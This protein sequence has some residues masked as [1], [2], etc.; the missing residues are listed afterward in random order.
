MK[1]RRKPVSAIKGLAPQLLGTGPALLNSWDMAEVKA[2]L[3]RKL[4]RKKFGR[5]YSITGPHQT[6]SHGWR[7]G[8]IRRKRRRR[9]ENIERERA[10]KNSIM[11]EGCVEVSVTGA[12]AF[13]AAHEQFLRGKIPADELGFFNIAKQFSRSTE[14]I[15]AILQ[16]RPNFK[17]RF[18][19][20]NDDETLMW[21][22]LAVG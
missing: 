16:D 19:I 13:R 17:L 1:K 7:Y 22:K 6:N 11:L 14:D 18:R 15:V 2:S 21:F 5:A 8:G 4:Y 3:D 12:A 20:K 9:G 10:R